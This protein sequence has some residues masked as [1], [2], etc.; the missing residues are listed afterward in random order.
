MDVGWLLG[1]VV[2]GIG[3]GV[4][5]DEIA[6]AEVSAGVEEVT[7]SSPPQAA[8]NNNRDTSR[9]TTGKGPNLIH[10][11]PNTWMLISYY[12]P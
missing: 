5:V 11:R 10:H 6:G 7:G 1:M 9:A 3:P 2:G 4:A 12:G 8:D